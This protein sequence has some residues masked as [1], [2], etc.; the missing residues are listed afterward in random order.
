MKKNLISSVLVLMGLAFVHQSVAQFTIDAQLRNRFEV[1]NGFWQLAAE[2]DNPHV[3]MSQ[4]SRLRFAY[5][6]EN[7]KLVFTPQDVRIWGDDQTASYAGF[8]GSD[9]SLDLFEAY[10]EIRLSENGWLSVGRQKFA[11]DN[12]S[13]ISDIDWLQNPPTNDAMVLKTLAGDWNV[14]LAT[15]WNSLDAQLAENPYPVNR[16]KTFNFLWLNR[17]FENIGLSLV[18]V[19]AGV[20]RTPDTNKLNFRNTTGVY[21]DYAK[22]DLSLKGNFYYQYGKNQAG[23]DVSAVLADGEIALKVGDLTPVAGFSYLSGNSKVGAEQTTDNLFDPLYRTRHGFFGFLDY[24]RAFGPHTSQGGL[25]NVYAGLNYRISEKTSLL[26][27]AHH[28]QLAQ[29]NAN[30]L[31]D[32]GLGFES[33]LVARYRFQPWAMLE[34]GWCFMLPTETLKQIQGVA[35]DKFSHFFYLQLNLTPRLFN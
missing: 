15:S 25:M 9:A 4:R 28:F 29:T 26:Y 21:A 14:H 6:S 19:L 30:T 10:A 5:Q 16:F 7:L 20:T 32:K 11:Y 27:R 23:T 24:F 17:R 3:H 35:N 2:G 8:Y 31:S 18:H 12:L 1:R 33:D 13:L 34:G 22:G